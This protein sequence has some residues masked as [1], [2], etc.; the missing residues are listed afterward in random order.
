MKYYKVL[1]NAGSCIYG[2]GKWY[3]PTKCKDGAWKPGKW[4]P[5]IK[6]DLEP[7]ENGYH[8]CR[9]QDLVRWLD[10]A[11]Y[12]VEYEG[13]RVDADDKIVVRKARLLR[14]VESWDER[15]AR[16]FACECAEHVLPIFEKEFPN[17]DR[18]RKA[19]EIARK[20]ANGKATKD[21]L[22]AARDA[23]Y[24]AARAAARAAA[25]DAAGNAAGAAARAAAWDAAGN[26]AGAAARDAAWDAAGN[27]A[28]N[29]A[30]AAA[31]AAEREW[32][33]QNL[34][35]LIGE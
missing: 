30:W 11:I 20:F 33:T 9:P 13:E 21:E 3:L 35:E 15:T 16:L 1:K 27:A 31:W 2:S 32:Q 22:D 14:K 17:D 10:E 25:W 29:A 28:W 26:A 12:E 23:A 4:M 18:P 8:L 34:F 19:I 5:E 24:A 6:G 7:C